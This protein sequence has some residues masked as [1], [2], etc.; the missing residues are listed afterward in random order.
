MFALELNESGYAELQLAFQLAELEFRDWRSGLRKLEPES[1]IVIQ[2]R[3]EQE[4]PGWLELTR[5]YAREKARKYPGKTILRRTDKG[6]LSFA[7][8]NEGNIARIEPLSGEYGSAVGYLV[9]HQ[10]TRPIIQFS[11]DD[12][13]RFFV[14]LLEDK[15]TRLR[16]L[17]F[18]A[19]WVAR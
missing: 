13:E 2:R 10:E 18:N 4:G 14:I 9:Y 6:Y 7:K 1:T 17:G 3:F 16:E 19:G 12:E 8:G 5:V 11:A 15:N